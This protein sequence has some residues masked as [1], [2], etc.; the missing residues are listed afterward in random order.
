[1]KCPYAKSVDGMD[2]CTITGYK[3]SMNPNTWPRYMYCDIYKLRQAE[4]VNEPPNYEDLII[5]E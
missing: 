4:L 1:M 3:C 5:S 2:W